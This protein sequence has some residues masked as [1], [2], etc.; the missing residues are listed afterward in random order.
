MIP[1]LVTMIWLCV[2]CAGFSRFVYIVY[3]LRYESLVT[4]RRMKYA[5]ALTW[6]VSFP[7]FPGGFT[8]DSLQPGKECWPSRDNKNANN[9]PLNFYTSLVGVAWLILL[10]FY[11]KILREWMKARREVIPSVSYA[12]SGVDESN[13]QGSSGNQSESVNHSLRITLMILPVVAIVF[14]TWLNFAIIMS[15]TS[16]G[17]KTYTEKILQRVA[18]WVITINYYSNPILYG[19]FHK[20]LRAKVKKFIKC[21]AN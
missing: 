1:P 16:R 17:R 7:A 8:R 2:H 20:D 9:R 10:I 4:E 18:V 6:I 15:L 21:N 12:G 13:T 19:L 11:I 14:I 3:P 5:V